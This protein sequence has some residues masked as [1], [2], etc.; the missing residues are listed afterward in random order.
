MRL[1][2]CDVPLSVAWG[3]GVSPRRSAWGENLE[4]WM[5]QVGFAVGGSSVVE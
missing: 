3:A 1:G 5:G 2:V 4:C